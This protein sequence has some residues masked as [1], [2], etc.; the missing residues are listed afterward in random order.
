MAAQ[1][2]AWIDLLKGF[3]ICLIILFHID[4]APRYVLNITAPLG[5]AT[6][7]F[8]SGYTFHHASTF[9]AHLLKKLRTLLLPWLIFGSFN[10]ILTQF[11]T[12]SEQISLKEQFFYFFLQIRAKNDGLWFFP[13]MFMT[14]C[15]F[16]FTSKYIKNL[17]IL[18]IVHF[19]LLLCGMVYTLNGGT[20]IP[21]H[22]QTLGAGSFYMLL[23]YLY[24]LKETQ[25]S[26]LHNPNILAVIGLAF[27]FFDILHQALYPSEQ[28]TFHSY[29][30]SPVFY[31]LVMF[32]GI[33]SVVEIAKKLPTFRII[34]YAG[35]NSLLYFSFHGKPK[36]LLEV[37]AIKLYPDI[38]SSFPLSL[39]VSIFI[40]VFIIFVLIIPCEVINRY[41]PFLL[42][43]PKTRL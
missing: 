3:S 12:F 7:F 33:I 38:V 20:P 28:I 26:F 5:M 40:V 29:G 4:F 22:I 21:W 32:T 37:L 8:A 17:Y 42:G 14:S 39:L 35:K 24:R 16:Y 13:C 18:I 43:R 15:L 11:L 34:Q 30:A 27:V 10:I 6:F 25:L 2:I 41:F 19:F 36:R 23:G 31:F 9:I 1:R